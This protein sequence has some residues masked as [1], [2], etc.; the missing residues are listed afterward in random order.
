MALFGLGK[1][2]TPDAIPA[3]QQAPFF[4]V[5]TGPRGA[6]A[7]IEHLLALVVE[8]NCSDLHMSVG[9]PP[10]VRMHGRL[11]KMETRALL[12]ED[13][14]KLVTE[15]ATPS[16]LDRAKNDGSV[17]FAYSFR[18]RNR[19]RCSIYLQKGTLAI[20]MRLIPRKMLSLDEIGMPP[21]VRS[22]LTLPRGLVLVTGPTGSGKTTSLAAMLDI[23]NRSA[24]AHIITIEDPIEYIHEHQ[25]GIVHQREVGAD[26]PT[27]G[28]GLRRA[29]RQDPDVIL[30]GEMRDLETM[31]TA[32]TA[33]ETGHLV[34]STLHTTGAGRTV[35]RIVDAFPA[36]QQ[37]QVRVQLAS[38]LRAVISQLL[39]PRI[40]RPGRIAVFEVMM[41]THS[42]GALIR[43]NKTFRIATEIQTGHKHGMVSLEASLVDLYLAGVI[44]R[45]EVFAKAQDTEMAAQLLAGREPR[46]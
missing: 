17:D 18:E 34:F 40:D 11:R 4:A 39:V 32:I 6:F 28:D 7:P 14:E 20:A 8:H 9:T 35:D 31:E 30:V 19:F 23:I 24:S 42:I 45:E 26:V 16:Q 27:F 25:G 15:I 36:H 2:S 12:P 43:D 3:A 37:E 5:Q 10:C 1:S 29:L 13:L 46:R 38:N 22:L 21:S 33:A 41:L 44:S